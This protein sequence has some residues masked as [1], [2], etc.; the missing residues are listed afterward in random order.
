[1]VK[2]TIGALADMRDASAVALQR[3]VELTKVFN[4]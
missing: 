3:G 4:G 1:V 2:A